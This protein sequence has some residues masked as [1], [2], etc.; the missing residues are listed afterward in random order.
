MAYTFYDTEGH[1]YLRVPFYELV[2]L[3]I[4]DEISK[5]SYL[6]NIKFGI[7][8][9]SQAYLEEDVDLGL[10]LKAKNLENLDDL[11]YKIKDVDIDYFE[12]DFFSRADYQ[13]LERRY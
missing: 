12:D 1:G 11:D 8:E 6:S 5:F 13:N 10:F 9:T 3:G 4:H 7:D 2:D